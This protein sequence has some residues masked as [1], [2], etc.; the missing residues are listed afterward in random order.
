[1]HRLTITGDPAFL[2]R[3]RDE[4]HKQHA[5]IVSDS[6]WTVTEAGG[7]LE[8]NTTDLMMIMSTPVVVLTDVQADAV[9]VS[10]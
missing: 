4:I 2:Q 9:R 8:F 10:G 3:V 7:V 1:M 5:A 6:S